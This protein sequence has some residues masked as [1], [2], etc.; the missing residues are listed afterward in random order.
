MFLFIFLKAIAI[1]LGTVMQLEP[2]LC[3]F[4]G[5]LEPFRFGVVETPC[6]KEIQGNLHLFWM[7][8]AAAQWM[9]QQSSSSSSVTTKG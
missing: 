8:V 7:I 4:D 1:V 6:N 5:I 9:Q 2:S 3:K